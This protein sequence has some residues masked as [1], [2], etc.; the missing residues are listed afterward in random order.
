VAVNLDLPQA[1]R[2]VLPIQ[3]TANIFRFEVHAKNTGKKAISGVEA[4]VAPAEATTVLRHEVSSDPPKG[5]PFDLEQRESDL[6]VTSLRL[7]QGQSLT[8]T[9]YTTSPDQPKVHVY[10][11]GGGDD[12]P[13]FEPVG[14]EANKSAEQHVVSIIRNLIAFVLVPSLFNTLL[15]IPLI[16]NER[17]LEEGPFQFGA[18][19]VGA[20]LRTLLQAYFLLRI[21]PHVLDLVRIFSATRAEQRA[22]GI[23]I[24]DSGTVHIH[25]PDRGSP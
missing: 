2:R 13:S 3:G 14:P 18:I 7:N 24:Q 25:S 16:F 6:H 1:V 4:I 23:L 15:A 10:W 21:V 17:L 19:G 11:S 9:L 8:I 5:I 20:L 22:S 12:P